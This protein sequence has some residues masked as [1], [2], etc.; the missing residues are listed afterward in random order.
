MFPCYSSTHHERSHRQAAS[1]WWKP[2][3]MSRVIFFVVFYFLI[4]RARGERV[5]KPLSQGINFCTRSVMRADTPSCCK[6]VINLSLLPRFSI[7]G[8]HMATIFSYFGDVVISYQLCEEN[9]GIKSSEITV[10]KTK[11]IFASYIE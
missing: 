6:K 5:W 10:H 3:Y 8:I 2:V 9:T 11:I 1:M 4:A 7:V